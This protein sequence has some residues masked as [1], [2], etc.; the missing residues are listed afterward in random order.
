MALKIAG[1]ALALLTLAGGPALAVQGAPCPAGTDSAVA[2]GFRR[3][4]ADSLAAAAATWRRVRLGCPRSV[5]ARYGLGLV[6]LRGGDL[7]GADSLLR[8]AWQ[9][10]PGYV[11]VGLALALVQERAGRLDEARQLARELHRAAPDDAAVT[12]FWARHF[13][14]GD[15]PAPPR[16]PRPDSLVLVSRTRGERFQVRT[17]TGWTDL[18]LQGVNLGVALPGRHPS[19]FPLDSARYAGWLD[20]LAGM[21]AN[22]V[23]VYTILPP[24][25]YRALR[26]RNLAHPDAPMWLIHGV[27]TELPPRDD[28]DD[29]HWKGEFRAEMRRVV[30]VLHG[31]AVLPPRAGHA[32]GTYDA[33]VSTW[34]MAYIIGREWEPFAVKA[35]DA[36]GGGGATRYRGRFLEMARGPRMDAWMAEQCDY[37]LGYEFD[38]YHALRPVAYTNW[39]T[40]DPLRHPTEA[41]GREEAAWRRRAGRPLVGSRREYENDAI[42]LDAALVHP[43]S[44]NPAGWFA[45]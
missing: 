32:S 3:Y 10:A 44:R 45:S 12:R 33:D 38:G 21:G 35:F 4:R 7:A 28:F 6:A 34:V 23:R 11:E 14:D 40:L 41:T 26:A 18:Y 22:T 19:E 15:R 36:A 43:T 31:Q 16:R 27:W 1:M 2:A 42:G 37:L 24:P 30:D 20:T 5:D 9:D 25:F 39:P 17:D 13:P 29:R 8:A